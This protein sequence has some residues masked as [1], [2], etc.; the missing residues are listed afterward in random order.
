MT[1]NSRLGIFLSACILGLYVVL[2]AKT[3]N[4]P[5]NPLRTDAELCAEVTVETQRSVTEGLLTATEAQTISERCY[6]T[7]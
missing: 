5:D 2:D 1:V 3:Q 6:A 7:L 4:R